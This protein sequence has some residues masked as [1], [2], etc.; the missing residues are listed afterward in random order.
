MKVENLVQAKAKP[1]TAEAENCH[2]TP[3]RKW[4]SGSLKRKWVSPTKKVD[5]GVRIPQAWHL[6]R[7]GSAGTNHWQVETPEKGQKAKLCEI[8]AHDDHMVLDPSSKGECLKDEDE[9]V[10]DVFGEPFGK[11][12]VGF[13]S[14]VRVSPTSPDHSLHTAEAAEK[15]EKKSQQ[16]TAK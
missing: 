5:Q 8:A 2:G 12:L 15:S 14:L 3:P 11:S 13:C 16:L 10:L 6:K 1:V 7:S 9:M 4:I